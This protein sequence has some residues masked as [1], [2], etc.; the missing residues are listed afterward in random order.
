MYETLYRWTNLVGKVRSLINLNNRYIFRRAA[1]RAISAPHQLRPAP[2][3]TSFRSSIP[4]I[5]RP[6]HHSRTWLADEQKKEDTE[7][8]SSSAQDAVSESSGTTSE[9]L[10]Q[11]EHQSQNVAET[12]SSPAQDAVS[13]SS[14]TTSEPVGQSEHQS[15]NV[16][17]NAPEP[18]Q[19]PESNVS[20]AADALSESSGTTSEPIGQSEHQP[21]SVTEQ[22]TEIADKAKDAASNVTQAAQD[23]L[24]EQVQTTASSATEKAQSAA[25]SVAKTA[26]DAFGAI[27]NSDPFA[28]RPVQVSRILYIGNLFFE[29]TA[30]QLEAEFSKFGEVTNSRVVTDGRGLSKGFGYIEMRT[31]EEADKARESLDQVVYQGRRISVQYHVRRN[32]NRNTPREAQAPSKT[33]F[34]GNMSYQMSDRDLN[35]RSANC[36]IVELPSLTNLV[37]SLQVNPQRP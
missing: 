19:Q 18:S 25:A 7:P 23:S 10:G 14:G 34:I 24:P 37:R 17:E 5:A 28:K 20:S 15:Q 2:C 13:E 22:A 6:F 1:A 11:S 12:T 36:L 8:T 33:L 26:R 35:G 9:P 4:S 32:S 27:D 3:M 16:A 29:V 30:P 31:Q 21:Q